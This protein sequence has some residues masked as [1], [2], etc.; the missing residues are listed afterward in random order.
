MK[1]K[2][3][4][5]MILV[6]VTL[7][8]VMVACNFENPSTD[9]NGD[10]VITVASRFG[11]DVPDEIFFREQVN[12][13]SALDNGITVEMI[14]IPTE[15]DYLNMLRTSF[16]NGDTP[17]VFIE[18]GGSRVA[19]YIEAG[20]LV[21]IAPYFEEYP[22]WYN[23][24]YP[25]MFEELIFDG[26]DGIWG[27]PFQAYMVIMYYNTELFEEHELMPPTTWDEMM[28][29]SQVFLDAGIR[30]FQAG[31]R[32]TWRLGHLHT[33]IVLKSLGS[34]AIT[35]LTNRTI[36][37]DSPEMLET[38]RLIYEMANRGFLGIDPLNTD[39]DTE[40][41]LFVAGEVAMRWDGTW[42][43]SEIFGTET[44]DRTGV[45]PFP[46]INPEF[47]RVAQ[48]GPSDMW[49]VSQLNKSDEEIAAS[50]EFL[51]FIASPE[52][53]AGNNEVASSLY[54]ARFTPTAATPANPLLDQ[55]N[56]ILGNMEALRP[57]LQNHDPEPH[58]LDTVRNS[59]QGLLMGISPEDVAQNIIS[60]M[61][62]PNPN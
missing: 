45:A 23:I 12:A 11:S 50:I 37:Y 10:I 48:G 55:V 41:A 44:Y 47:A 52:Y 7:M 39:Y 6:V 16:A 4:I 15:S 27:V 56:D 57:D 18:Y 51:R 34:D 5:I 24:F 58:M 9:G 21:N 14:N 36:A 3:R 42:F 8:I 60:Q 49:F 61:Q 46:T 28:E 2:L 30:P 29:V 38:F 17:N 1:E 33:N 22:E 35:G 26:F 40:K 19:E 25:A 53:F 43:I 20:A 54:P 13:F 62:N 32:D 31:A 59:L